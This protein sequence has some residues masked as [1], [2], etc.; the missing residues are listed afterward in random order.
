MF[1]SALPLGRK[2]LSKKENIGL[3]K[4]KDK[5]MQFGR[6]S[7]GKFSHL[8]GKWKEVSKFVIF[9]FMRHLKLYIFTFYK[10]N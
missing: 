5:E 4:D 2:F 3:W 7:E 8:E 1:T 10:L 9:Q 6:K